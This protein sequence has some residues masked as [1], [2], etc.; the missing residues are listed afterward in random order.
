[1]EMEEEIRGSV[2][3]YTDGHVESTALELTVLLTEG[4]V[5]AAAM[6]QAVGTRARLQQVLLPHFRPVEAGVAAG[7]PRHARY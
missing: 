2:C 7:A 4:A 6:H 1:M 3:V 5:L